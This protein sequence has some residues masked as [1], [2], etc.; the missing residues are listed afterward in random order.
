MLDKVHLNPLKVV[1]ELVA[2]IQSL[3]L[4]VEWSLINLLEMPITYN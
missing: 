4:E 2:I 3:K 1:V